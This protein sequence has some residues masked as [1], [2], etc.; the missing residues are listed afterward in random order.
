MTMRRST[1]VRQP[2]RP[3]LTTAYTYIQ[4]IR[5]GAHGPIRISR[6]LCYLS[7]SCPGGHVPGGGGG[8]GG[9]GSVSGGAGGGGG[10]GGGGGESC[11]LKAEAGDAPCMARCANAA[12]AAGH[13][14]PLT[15]RTLPTHPPTHA[16]PSRD[17][18]TPPALRP[19]TVLGRNERL[20]CPVCLARWRAVLISSL[21]MIPV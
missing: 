7:G 13:A 18:H 2:Y 17:P 14:A 12:A 19:T 20:S 5:R 4:A 15:Q 16:T 3:P 6:W 1:A 21:G 10:G 11:G 8:G 9:G